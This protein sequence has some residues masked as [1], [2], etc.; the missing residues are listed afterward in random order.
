MAGFF[1][2]SIRQYERVSMI[3]AKKKMHKASMIKYGPNEFLGKEGE[4][5]IPEIFP[6]KYRK[7]QLD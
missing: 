7:I 4:S 5:S 6:I 2:N 1:S 3:M